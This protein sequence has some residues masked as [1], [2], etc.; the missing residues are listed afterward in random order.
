M[1]HDL[2]FDEIEDSFK[3]EWMKEFNQDT[4]KEVIEYFSPTPI[5]EGVYFTGNLNLVS[6]NVVDK[7]ETYP[8]QNIMDAEYKNI[9]FEVFEKYNELPNDYGVADDVDQVL[10]YYKTYI[11]D[12]D[13]K[14]AIIIT[15]VLRSEEPSDGGWRWHKWGEY[16]GN[17][18]P[19][20]EYLYD[21]TDIDKI[22]LFSVVQILN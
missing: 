19:S 15:P 13:R 22:V 10:K 16:I 2:K 18:N 11:D 17:Q 14:F 6:T 20:S 21:E 12:K 9:G 5:K 1:L 3:E 7:V 8:K 4:D